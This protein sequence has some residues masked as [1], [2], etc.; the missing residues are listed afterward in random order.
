MKNKFKEKGNDDIH[1]E[2]AFQKYL[3]LYENTS[4]KEWIMAKNEA[5]DKQ[6]QVRFSSRYNRVPI[7]QR[8]FKNNCKILRSDPILKTSLTPHANL[9]FRRPKDLRSKLRTKA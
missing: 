7:I 1:I 4:Q 8:I 3:Q 2:E 5:G 9:V 6:L